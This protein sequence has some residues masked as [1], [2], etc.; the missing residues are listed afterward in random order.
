M[1]TVY[2]PFVIYVQK[3]RE[4]IWNDIAILLSIFQKEKWNVYIYIC[5]DADTVLHILPWMCGPLQRRISL[6]CDASKK[7]VNIEMDQTLQRHTEDS[8]MR[9]LESTEHQSKLIII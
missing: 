4:R 2:L 6:G 5:L 8:S 3:G 9:P 7:L 1:I